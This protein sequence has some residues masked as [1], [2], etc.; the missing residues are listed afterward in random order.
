MI[1][2]HTGNFAQY[3]RQRS[4]HQERLWPLNCALVT[5]DGLRG[6]F[7]RLSFGLEPACGHPVER[8][9]QLIN[10]VYR[11]VRDA[12]TAVRFFRGGEDGILRHRPPNRLPRRAW[13][14][15][16]LRGFHHQRLFDI[17]I[18]DNGCPSP[19]S[20]QELPVQ[21]TTSRW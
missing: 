12:R 17:I 15:R 5:P 6:G 9:Y 10:A 18:D 4:R 16:E 21:R 2:I 19:S 7:H 1:Y 20:G 11:G 8:T 13:R 14:L 3:R